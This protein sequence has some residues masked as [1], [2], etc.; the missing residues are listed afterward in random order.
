MCAAT[1]HPRASLSVNSS[2]G[3]ENQRSQERGLRTRSRLARPSDPRR[4]QRIVGGR[5]RCGCIQNWRPREPPCGS[6]GARSQAPKGLEERGDPS[7]TQAVD[8]AL[9][10]HGPVEIPTQWAGWRHSMAEAL[11]AGSVTTAAKAAGFDSLP[12]AI[13]AEVTSKHILSA[14]LRTRYRLRPVCSAEGARTPPRWSR[15]MRLGLASDWE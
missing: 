13:P 11:R 6:Q 8:R 15:A 2:G 3:T 7:I 9:R 4:G 1:T 14:D 10:R 5:L 12:S